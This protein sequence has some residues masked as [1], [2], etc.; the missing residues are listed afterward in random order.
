MS[1][2]MLYEKPTIP[3]INFPIAIRAQQTVKRG[4]FRPSHWHE[5]VEILFVTKGSI[6][7]ECNLDPIYAFENDIVV[8]NSNEMHKITNNIDG[9]LYYAIIFDSKFVLSSVLDSC[10]VK[11]INPISKNDIVFMNK[12]TGDAEMVSVVKKVILEYENKGTYFELAIKSYIYWLLVLLLRN[13]TETEMSEKVCRY[14]STNLNKLNKLLIYIEENYEHPLTTEDL[15]QTFNTSCSNLQHSFKKSTGR[16]LRDYINSVRIYN[17]NQLIKNSDMSI[18][19]IALSVGFQDG[20][21]FSRL[22]KK[23]KGISPSSYRKKV[24]ASSHKT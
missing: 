7:V 18:T 20:N 4:L 21:Y 9:T 15:A 13:Y 17:A 8:V 11:Y 2:Q 23:H 14:R 3:D 1:D 19:E 10:D 5:H 24:Q 22:Y 12:V 16:T 6:I